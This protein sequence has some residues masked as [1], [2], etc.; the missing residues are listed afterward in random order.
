M[1]SAQNPK[2]SFHLSPNIGF[3]EKKG[4]QIWCRTK[5]KDQL[6]I[7]CHN[8]IQ[9]FDLNKRKFKKSLLGFV[10]LII[11]LSDNLNIASCS[12]RKIQIWDLTK[13]EC[14]RVLEGHTGLVRCLS[15]LNTGE[16]VSGSDDKQIKI[17]C[18]KSGVCLRNL[19]ENLDSV[20]SM[21]LVSTRELA[22]IGSNDNSI[23]ILDIKGENPFRHLNGH[24]GVI[25]CLICSI[26]TNEIATAS[27]DKTIKIW[28]INVGSCNTLVGHKKDVTCLIFSKD[29]ILTSGSLD[30]TIKQWDIS[31]LV[32]LMTINCFK[33][34]W[35]FVILSTNELFSGSKNDQLDVWDLSK[36]YHLKSFKEYNLRMVNSLVYSNR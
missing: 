15:Q 35:C 34:M 28:Q 33:P 12:Y 26:N 7:S 11:K 21:I 27:A 25:H 4:K 14:V 5:K 9:I 8:S 18:L 1:I 19:N 30:Q 31:K 20:W 32:C 24:T 29:N 36:G 2:R 13:Y 6:L 17:W 22:F 3:F 23:K 10:W 16:L